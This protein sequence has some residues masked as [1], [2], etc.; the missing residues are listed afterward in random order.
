[1][2]DPYTDNDSDSEEYPVEDSTPKGNPESRD[3]DTGESASKGKERSPSPLLFGTFIGNDQNEAEHNL[4]P[5]LTSLANAL[6][7]VVPW[8]NE[9]N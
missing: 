1:M 3:I 8:E 4:Q 5:P 7:Y 2:S 6:V 9:S